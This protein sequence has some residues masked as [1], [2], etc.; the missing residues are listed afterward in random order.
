[1]VKNKH[2]R[3]MLHKISGLS[4]I[5]S[6]LIILLYIFLAIFTLFYSEFPSNPLNKWLIPILGI[7]SILGL[8]GIS[9]DLFVKHTKEKIKNKQTSYFVV[10]LLLFTV[11][12]VSW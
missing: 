11:I 12:V 1:M 7:A 3:K 10:I 2:G 6:E 4:L 9:G 8:I 5:L